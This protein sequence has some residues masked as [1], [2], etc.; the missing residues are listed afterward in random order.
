MVLV[1]KE[2]AR[3][4]RGAGCVGRYLL[5][6][7]SMYAPSETWRHFVVELKTVCVLE[8]F[9]RRNIDGLPCLLPLSEIKE[10]VQDF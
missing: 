3:D 6:V 2:E 4:G 1:W 9:M 10:S 7:A 8:S 5:G